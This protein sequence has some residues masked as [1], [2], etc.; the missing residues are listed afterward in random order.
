MVIGW[1]DQEVAAKGKACSRCR[2]ELDGAFFGWSRIGGELADRIIAARYNTLVQVI[3]GWQGEGRIKNL[4]IYRFFFRGRYRAGP[5]GF[6]G[7]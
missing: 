6:E 4:I 7:N 1:F 5:R 3:A 2:G